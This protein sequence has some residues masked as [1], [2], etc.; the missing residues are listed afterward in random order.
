MNKNKKPIGYT[1]YGTPVYL[2]QITNKDLLK[3]MG[4][5]LNPPAKG[6]L[7]DNIQ[8]HYG[9]PVVVVIRM[10]KKFIR[11]FKIT[12]EGLLIP[13]ALNILSTECRAKLIEL[14][15]INEQWRHRGQKTDGT[16]K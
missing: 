16:Y 10:D 7:R 5:A 12:E 15:V 11:V 4:R 6:K 1:N 8:E 3:G 13:S 2:M 14:K 9:A